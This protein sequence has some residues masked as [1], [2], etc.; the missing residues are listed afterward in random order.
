MQATF[1]N[2]KG[3]GGNNATA[4]ILSPFVTEAMLTKRH[5]HSAMQNFKKKQETVAEATRAYDE[6]C[7]KG[8]TQPIYRFGEG[9]VEGDA[10]TMTPAAITVPGQRQPISL[11]L[12]NPYEDMV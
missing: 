6:A 3:F 4:A 10:L 11:S 12:N 7:L 9:V 1:I 2:S 8:E 5:G